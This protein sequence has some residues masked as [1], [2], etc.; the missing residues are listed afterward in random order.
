[1]TPR[2]MV[3]LVQLHHKDVPAGVIIAM[4]DEKRKEFADR[5]GVVSGYISFNTTGDA[6][7]YELPR[8]ISSIVRV[9][10]DG[11]RLTRESPIPSG[12]SDS[13]LDYDDGSS[14]VV[15]VYSGAQEEGQL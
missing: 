13:G 1:M 14:Y 12:T 10:Y 5:T 6:I 15:P 8:T 7:Y 11:S 9:D 4:L 2:R 3:E